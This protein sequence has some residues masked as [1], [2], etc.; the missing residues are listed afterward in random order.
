MILPSTS[1][2][3]A[4]CG[5]SQEL[6]RISLFAACWTRRAF[7]SALKTTAPTAAW[8]TSAVPASVN[9]PGARLNLFNLFTVSAQINISEAE[10]LEAAVSVSGF[11]ELLNP[12]HAGWASKEDIF[13]SDRPAQDW[14]GEGRR[15]AIAMGMAA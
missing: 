8:V 7:P 5:M 2:V 15:L 3:S 4:A 12:Y 9:S 11:C 13:I 14:L 1:T 6:G 10:L